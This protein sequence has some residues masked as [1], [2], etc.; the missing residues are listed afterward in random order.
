MA[1]YVRKD[2]KSIWALLNNTELKA[3]LHQKLSDSLY[4]GSHK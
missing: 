3:S 2:K 1:N 4:K